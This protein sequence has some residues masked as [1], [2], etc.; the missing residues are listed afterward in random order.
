MEFSFLYF[1]QTIHNPILDGVMILFTVL[2]EFGIIWI[3]TALFLLCFPKYRSFSALMLVSML[4]TFLIGE[5]GLKNLVMRERPLVADPTVMQLIPLPSG[6]SFP[7]GHTASS[8]AAAWILLKADRKLGIAGLLLAGCIG[9]SRLYLF[10]HYPTDV[11]GGAVLGILC[12]QG[13]F[14]IYQWK[15][16]KKVV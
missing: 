3:L 12:A 13:I 5:I 9:F 4:V 16:R 15:T 11:L 1:L 8:F 6:S 10:V 14:M 2:G 7:S